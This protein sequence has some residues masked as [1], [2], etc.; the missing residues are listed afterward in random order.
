MCFNLSAYFFS[1]TVLVCLESLGIVSWTQL[2]EQVA[3]VCC[4]Q[5][6]AVFQHPSPGVGLYAVVYAASLRP[7]GR[8]LEKR[9]KG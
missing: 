2:Q 5:R 3:R 6:A 9:R 7:A 8:I 1:L 4:S